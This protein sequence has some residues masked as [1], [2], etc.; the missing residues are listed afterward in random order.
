M[1]IYICCI[2]I[3][4]YLKL[5]TYYAIVLYTTSH[6]FHSTNNSFLN[7]FNNHI[8]FNNVISCQIVNFD[9]YHLKIRNEVLSIKYLKI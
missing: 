4:L 6:T 5:L 3:A 1:H 9:I 8:K 7:F 2:K